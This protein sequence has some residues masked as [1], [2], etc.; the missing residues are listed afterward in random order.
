MLERKIEI[1][2]AYNDRAFVAKLPHFRENFQR[3]TARLLW[4]RN[5]N[6]S[7]DQSGQW[8]KSVLELGEDRCCSVL[9]PEVSQLKK[10][11]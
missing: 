10:E 3:A 11:R 8:S 6:H 7:L 1:R 9:R 2:N 4:T 5:G